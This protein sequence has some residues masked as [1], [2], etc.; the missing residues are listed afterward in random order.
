M[1]IKINFHDPV[2]VR[3]I[4]I[5]KTL[6]LGKPAYLQKDRGP[7]LR[8][9]L[10]TTNQEVWSHQR[11]NITHNLF[12]DKVKEML[13]IGV[14]SGSKLIKSLENVVGDSGKIAEIKGDDYARDFTCHVFSTIMFGENYPINTGLF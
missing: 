14:V 2:L 6:D 11:K 9:G 7:L 13:S 10:I 12:V 8:K 4:N 1:S 5:S 3:E